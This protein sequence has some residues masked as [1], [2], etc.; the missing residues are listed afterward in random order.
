M[1]EINNRKK[2]NGQVEQ[3]LLAEGFHRLE[4]RLVEKRP[5]KIKWG[6][7]YQAK[8]ALE[9]II[10]LEKLAAAMNHAAYLV[11]GER[12]KLGELCAKKEQQLV[13]MKEAL[14]QNNNM[15]QVQVTKMNEERQ[16]YNKA[17]AVL[18]ARVRE[19]EEAA[20]HYS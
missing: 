6:P 13:A 5:P 2:G 9:K 4:P 20:S 10:Y 12:D 19:L 16:Q 1:S 14:N 18:N 8:P 7:I 17:I 3:D 11:Q 15:I